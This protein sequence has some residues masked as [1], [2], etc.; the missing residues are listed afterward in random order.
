MCT[1]PPLASQ[2]FGFGVR[3]QNARPRLPAAVREG[4]K[5][6]DA[7]SSHSLGQLRRPW[8]SPKRSKLIHAARCSQTLKFH[9]ISPNL[10]PIARVGR[11]GRPARPRQQPQRVPRHRPHPEH[12]RTTGDHARLLDIAKREGAQGFRSYAGTEGSASFRHFLVASFSLLVRFA[13]AGL[14]TSVTNG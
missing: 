5:G 3:R 6:W 14:Y 7:A 10:G 4:Y 2:I 13:V 8:P 9:Q 12:P 1:V 11:P